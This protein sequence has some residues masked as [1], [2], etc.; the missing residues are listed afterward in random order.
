MTG[1]GGLSLT[2]DPVYAD[3]TNAG[4]ASASYTYAGDTNHTGSSDAKTFTIDKA[5]STTAV[6]CPLVGQTYTGSALT[7]CA[8]EVTGAGLTPINISGDIVYAANINVGTATADVSWSG[9][10]NHFGSTATQATFGIGK[11]ASASV[12]TCPLVSQTYT[13]SALTPCTAEVTGAGLTPINISGDI[14]YAANTNVGTAT[15]DVSWSGDANHEGS[16]ATQATFAIGKAASATVITC[17]LV[18]QTYTG[19]ALTP[20]TAE[21]TGAGL[22]PINLTGSISYDA[23]INVGTATADVSWSGD[24]NHFGSTATQATFGIGKAASATVITCPLV[25]QTYTGSA[26]TP[27]TAEVTGAGLTPIN[28]TGDI[29]YAANT[30]VGTATADVSWSGDANHFGSTA[31]QATFVY[32][33]RPP[34]RPSSP[35]RW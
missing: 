5:S 32:S 26:L 12:I 16:T 15:A 10:A 17:P 29:V 34:V 31:T 7:P 25:S 2:P 9:D 1:A 20:C 24:A 14:V 22:T 18:S 19:S 33:A 4:T 28:I 11:A 30:N 27:C 23:N 6:T 3:N 21:V 13:G 8:A 35:A